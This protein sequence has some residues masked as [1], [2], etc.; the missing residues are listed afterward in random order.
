MSRPIGFFAVA[1]LALFIAIFGPLFTLAAWLLNAPVWLF[2]LIAAIISVP[3]CYAF[4]FTLNNS[5]NMQVRWLW[6]QLL[7]VGTVLLPLVVIGTFLTLFINSQT[8]GLLVLLLWPIGIIVAIWQALHIKTEKLTFSSP[9]VKSPVRL[10]QLSDVHIGSRS[11][12]FLNKVV[13]RALEHD[14]H[15]VVITGDLLDASIV[16]EE[17]LTALS[18]FNCPVLMCI[19]N[20]ERYVDLEKAIRAI[21]AHDVVVLRDE[22]TESHGIKFIGIDDRDRPDQLPSVLSNIE[23]SDHYKVLLYHRPDGWQSSLNAGIDLMLAGHTHAGQMWPFGLL[24][25]RQYPNMA[26]L[27]EQDNKHLYVSMGTGTWGPI[28]RLGTRSEMTVIDLQ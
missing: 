11:A 20:H 12:K 5:H 26:G 8:V 6:M 28:F 7:G 3:G 22:H 9:R 13:Q 16:D 10:V 27:F 17:D 4:W 18:R 19:G 1:S 23:D 25:K 2:L 24:V 15:V 21:E 14:P